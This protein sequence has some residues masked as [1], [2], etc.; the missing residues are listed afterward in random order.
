MLNKIPRLPALIIDNLV[1]TFKNFTV[2]MNAS[3]EQL[4]DVEG[5][6]EVRAKKIREGLRLIKNHLHAERTI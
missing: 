6:G 5:I 2:I 4:D 1:Q 3:V